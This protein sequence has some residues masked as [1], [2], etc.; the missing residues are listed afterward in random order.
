MSLAD[1][2][3]IVMTR[4]DR[5][6]ERKVSRRRLGASAEVAAGL[7]E[8]IKQIAWRRCRS[9]AFLRP[10]LVD[11]EGREGDKQES[12]GQAEPTESALHSVLLVLTRFSCLWNE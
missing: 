7:L 12:M 4:S 8:T 1:P 3:E 2:S 9:P 5:P 10:D 6:D 11:A